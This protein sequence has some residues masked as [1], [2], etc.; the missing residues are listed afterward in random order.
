[1]KTTITEPTIMTNDLLKQHL[2]H[3]ITNDIPL[4]Q[5][6]GVTVTDYEP[7]KLSLSAPLD[8]NYNHNQTTF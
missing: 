8:K 6:I 1:M 7:L 2:Q 4:S 3:K 5:H